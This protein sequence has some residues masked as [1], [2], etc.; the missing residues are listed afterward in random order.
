MPGQDAPESVYLTLE[1]PDDERLLAIARETQINDPQLA[2]IA[3]VLGQLDPE[4]G[5]AAA[6][7]L[8]R[9]GDRRHRAVLRT[10]REA[11]GAKGHDAEARA[12]R[13][14]EGLIELRPPDWVERADLGYRMLD[15]H[16]GV[17]VF[18]EDPLAAHWHGQLRWGPGIR[19]DLERAPY[20]ARP[21]DDASGLVARTEDGGVVLVCFHGRRRAPPLRLT[22]AGFARDPALRGLTRWST[23]RSLGRSGGTLAY[24][25]AGEP[26]VRL[27]QEAFLP[28]SLLEG[29]MARL[30][31]RSRS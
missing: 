6:L 18:V 4:E 13:I 20:L 8:A 11:L 23:V 27:P 3:E 26:P 22:R 15:P 1:I 7:S 29:F 17:S 31:K 19:P 5:A 10:Y 21:S 9:A 16:D 24:E 28:V 2:G 30:L 25:V 14:G 12:V